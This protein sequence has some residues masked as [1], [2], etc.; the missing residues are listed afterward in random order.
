M[1]KRKRKKKSNKI[2]IDQI[3]LHSRY[4][5]LFKEITEDTA[6]EIVNK[7][8]ALSKLNNNPIALYINSPG[9]CVDS[10]FSIIDAIQGVPCPVITVVTGMA[11][12]MAGIVSIAGDKRFM[13]RNSIWMSHDMAG[14]IWGDYTTKVIARAKYLEDAQKKLFKFIQEKTKLTLKDI[15]KAIHQ[16]LWLDAEQCLK[17][18]VIDKIV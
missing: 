3:L 13:T 14:G 15:N 7:I 17:K 4:I 9:G 6:C 8:V 16:E 2:D 12:S 5:Y 1:A 10:G 11:C 18:E